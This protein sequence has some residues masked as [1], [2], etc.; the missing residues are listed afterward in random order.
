MLEALSYQKNQQLAKWPDSEPNSTASLTWK[1]SLEDCRA[2]RT[3]S[4]AQ[5]NTRPA[6]HSLLRNTW[7]SFVRSPL[8]LWSLFGLKFKGCQC[9]CLYSYTA[10]LHLASDRTRW[11]SPLHEKSPCSEAFGDHAILQHV[12]LLSKC[13]NDNMCNSWSV[14]IVD[15]YIIHVHHG[16]S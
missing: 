15:I 4:V 11:G 9:Q 16:I 13:K 6:L 1:T 7:C 2:N 3:P 14:L 12:S 10:T 5:K 8:W